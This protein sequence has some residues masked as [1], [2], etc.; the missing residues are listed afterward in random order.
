MELIKSV[1]REK[2]GTRVTRRLRDSGMIPGVIYGHGE[3]NA[4]FSIDKHDLDIV[5]KRG[6]RLVEL[7]LSGK[8]ETCLIKAVQRDAFGHQV[9]HVDL[10]RVDLNE[11]VQVTVPVVLRGV[12]KGEAQGGVLTPGVQS[13]SIECVVTNIPDE[14]R[15]DV[16]ELDI[17]GI[18]RVHD[19]PPIPGGK[20]LTNPEVVVASCS[21]I[22]EAEVAAPVPGEEVAEPEVIGRKVEE[23]GEGEEGAAAAPEK[24]EKKEKK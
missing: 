24:E 12:P 6:E 3:A 13:L 5:L 10:T 4:F 19:L 21:V 8:K 14:I 7:E 2:L 1:T 23:E 18:L 20:I 22:T 15:V 16:R 11:T 17:N 9:V